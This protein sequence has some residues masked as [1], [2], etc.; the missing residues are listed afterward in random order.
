MHIGI[1]FASPNTRVLRSQVFLR[2]LGSYGFFKG[3]HYGVR[4]LKNKVLA[5]TSDSY[6]V[7]NIFYALAMHVR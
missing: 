2:C 1:R 5:L 7:Q 4:A 6:V 3:S